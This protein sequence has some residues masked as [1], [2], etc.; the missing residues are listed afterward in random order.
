MKQDELPIW[1]SQFKRTKQREII[2]RILS[3]SPTPQ[4]AQ[5]IFIQVQKEAPY[6][7]STIYRVLSALESQH[8]ITRLTLPNEA[9]P[10]YEWNRGAHLHYGVCLRCHKRFPLDNCPF[11]HDLIKVQDSSFQV[12]AHKL[13]VYGYC[14]TCQTDKKES[15]HGPD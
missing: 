4:N 3:E 10:R 15:S 5:D 11:E 14:M 8:M 2:C 7:L 9:V 12:V 1:S 13:E 6:A